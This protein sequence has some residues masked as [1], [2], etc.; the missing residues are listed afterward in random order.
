[1]KVT[2]GA[3]SSSMLSSSSN[4]SNAESIK[5]KITTM[6]QQLSKLSSKNNLE[7]CALLEPNLTDKINN[8]EVI[9]RE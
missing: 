9:F 1:M 6:K 5:K 8:R 7:L 4:T 2:N 3:S